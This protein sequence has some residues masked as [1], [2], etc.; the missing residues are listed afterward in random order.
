MCILHG[1]S[2]LSMA[3]YLLNGRDRDI[4]IDQSTSAGMTGHM[5]GDMFG[6]SDFSADFLDSLIE[7]PVVSC[8]KKLFK[9]G[10]MSMI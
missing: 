3:Y 7:M 6:N 4:P 1:H 10:E 8:P 5:G 2:E 9:I